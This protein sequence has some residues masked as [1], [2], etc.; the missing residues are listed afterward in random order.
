MLRPR[1]AEERRRA[2]ILMVVL[3]LLTLFAIVG[4][5][6]VF[7]AQKN[8]S[9][10]VN[11]REALQR[12]P[13][14]GGGADPL[15]RWAIG[16]LIYD[17]PDD[18]SGVQSALRGHSLARTMYGYNDQVLNLQPYNG[19]GRLHYNQVAAFGGLDDYQLVNYTYFKSDN[20]LR[21]PER[22]GTRTD[23]TNL[24]ARGPHTG[25]AN[26]SH[27]YPDLNNLFLGAARAN[28]TLM[29]PS[30]HRPWLFGTL[31]PSNPNWLATSP[32]GK[33]LTLRPR[34]ADMDPSFPYPSDLTGDVKNRINAPGGNDSIWI[35]LG[36]P[37]QTA[38]DGSKYKPLFAF[39]VEDLDNRINL[40][41]AGNLMGAST[42]GTPWHS[43]NR[44]YGKWEV[45]LAQMLN[46]Q[47]DPTE[48]RNLFRGSTSTSPATSGRYGQA[49]AQPTS[50]SQP[51]DGTGS[52]STIYAPRF[53][54]QV[55]L[56]GADETNSNAPTGPISSPLATAL[57]PF[58]NFPKGYDN[59]SLLARTNHAV[60]Y[61]YFQPVADDT[62]L[63]VA[64]MKKLLY[65][66]ASGSD[67]MSAVVATLCP[68]NFTTDPALP[69]AD[70]LA[71]LR[72]RQMV[73]TLSMDVNRLGLA[74]W[75]YRDQPSQ[76]LSPGA[77]LD[78][79]P[80]GPATAF[81]SLATRLD[82]TR[83]VPAISDFR[84]P[85]QPN[86]LP[87]GAPNP[88]VDW[89]S[90]TAALEKVD[91]GQLLPRYPHQGGPAGTPMLKGYNGRYDN[92]NAY[93]I[94][95]STG[96][97]YTA[98]QV[99]QQYESAQ[100]AR[101]SLAAEIY[102]RLLIVTGVDGPQ[103]AAAP[104]PDELAR[105]R[106]LGQLAVNIVDFIDEDEISTPFN[107]YAIAYKFF[108]GN[109]LAVT[110]YSA[111]SDKN[112][113]GELVLKYWVFGTELPPVVLNE[114]LAEYQVSATALPNDPAIVQVWAE[115][116]SPFPKQVTN[117]N[118]QPQE[119]DAN[120]QK[121]PLYHKT[122][123]NQMGTDYS[124]YKVVISQTETSGTPWNISG[125][126]AGTP[127]TIRN[128]GTFT[129]QPAITVG[130]PTVNP[131]TQ[132]DPQTGG[133]FLVGPDGLTGGNL[134]TNAPNT[135]NN[136]INVNAPDSVPAA[137]PWYQCPY[138][139]GTMG[140]RYEGTR[141]NN[142]PDPAFLADQTNG[143]TILLRRLANPH[144]PPNPNQT[145][146]DPI[147]GNPVVDTTYNPYI[148]VDYLEG[149][150]LWDASN[151]PTNFSTGKSQPYAS[152][153]S[154]VG[155]QTRKGNATTH[156]FGQPNDPAATAS[157]PDWLVHLDRT[158]VSPAELLHV[159]GFRPHEL[160]H[161]FINAGAS[162]RHRVPWFDE[163][164]PA[165]T[166]PNSHRLWRLFSFLEV[167][168][169]AARISPRGR[170][171]GKLN[172]NT[173]WELEVFQALCDAAI[174][175]ATG[176]NAFSDIDVKNMWNAL[177]ASR[178]P[179]LGSNK[180][181]SGD[182]PFLELAGVGHLPNTDLQAALASGNN[183]GRGLE[184]TVFRLQ[185]PS[186]ANPQRLFQVTTSQTPS[187]NV[188]ITH[189]YLQYDMLTK[190]YNNLT[191]RSNTF[192]VWLTVGFFEVKDPSTIPVKLGAEI[193]A[194]TATNIR[195]RFFCIV[196]RTQLV[197]APQLT[198]STTAVTQ[199]GAQTI[200]VNAPPGL[201]GS[202]TYSGGGSGT[203]SIQK[204][205]ILVVDRGSANE[206]TVVVTASSLD[207]G[208]TL[209]ANSFQ[210][211]FLRPH[212]QGFSITMP[213]NPG[214]QPL[215]DPTSPAYAP[216]VPYWETL[217]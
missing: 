8:H 147:T 50:G 59:G 210:A 215:F 5:T 177:L 133:S 195:H 172:I 189:P 186:G 48:W 85:G 22:L 198:S 135:R 197:L 53:F 57:F 180:I 144:L 34:P 199:A 78:G 128:E 63:P 74:P 152:D 90:F 200:T 216:V 95:P 121:I 115:L 89:R 54:N 106:W 212:S 32:T 58:P 170:T 70:Q 42:S 31:A 193:G 171:P 67:A 52:A 83:T 182:R 176:P 153:K 122:I 36:Y 73:T 39:Y 60:L 44:G 124:I 84:T 140:M 25:G 47:R 114:A 213:G 23:P 167:A 105:L 208:S 103:N 6:F 24:N 196:D 184:D 154:Q 11:F 16:Q 136:S 116:F 13:Y 65:S 150:R 119:N 190:V 20:I 56:N 148:T 129:S 113:N 202:I 142:A 201:S 81:P 37:V 206:E 7:F 187:G 77:N 88:A 82:T 211:I 61:D 117:G 17:V 151:A 46:S 166:P 33:Y 160:T 110:D 209:P 107:Y 118:T 35:D 2:V 94:D 109:D 104:T 87:G 45:S 64:D 68:Q 19:T 12:N 76:Y 145:K 203:W 125:N 75:L 120:E 102:R 40:N 66:G 158:P 179:N 207:P 181:D 217:Q 161:A 71:N 168:D 157:P 131:P 62:R 194:S 100:Q 27:T 98:T 164:L 108:T 18:L 112:N 173:I 21:D 30:F 159:S 162:Q 43:S 92:S 165:A 169:R 72:R 146:L 26:A 93:A 137:T 55:D 130:D 123:N 69:A 214:P 205:S 132:V 99:Q 138:K 4:I 86:Y 126:V 14:S 1:H 97:P 134:A 15:F 191:T 188:T 155:K 9:A 174:S 111:N 143:V 127:G 178:T 163:D 204:G 96:L 80:Y 49:V 91:L 41:T 141:I 10:S 156:T 51:G 192:G 28:G 29:M 149:V 38:P 183:K 101:Q 3:A 175:P 79:V 139:A 185:D